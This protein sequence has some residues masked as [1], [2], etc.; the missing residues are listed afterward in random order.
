MILPN[1]IEK[2]IK[3][4]L[5]SKK[6]DG[7]TIMDMQPVSGGCIN[8]A[9]KIIT[10][11]GN[12]F[13]KWN[14]NASEKMFD[15]EVKGLELL[16]KSKTIYIPQIIAYDHNY[17]MMEFIEKE[18]PSNILWEEFGRDL[19]ELHKVSNINFGLDHNNFIGSL[20]QD[21]KQQLSWSDFFINQRIIPQLSM[22]DFSPDFIRDFDK[23]FLKIDALFPEE[24]S[25]LLHGDLW[26][27]NFIFLNN[28]TALIDPAVYFGSR[29]MDIAM[30][31]LFGGFH[32]QFYSSYNENYPLSEGWQERIDICN[33]YP[34]LVHVNLF[35]GGYYSQVKT[36]LNRFI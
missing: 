29:E 25:S 36:I 2:E 32:D 15:T 30:S 1:A 35:G 21:N 4:I 18:S 34:L 17:L 14:I 27:G 5:I 13:L 7:I 9:T 24:P 3:S 33:L 16:R 8:N 10:N 11:Y 22:G 6:G 28:K 20:P 12:F 19:S 31:K 26:N 23:L